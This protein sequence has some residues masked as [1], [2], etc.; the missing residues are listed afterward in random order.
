MTNLTDFGHQRRHTHWSW[1][2][3]L[4]RFLRSGFL[5]FLFHFIL[6]LSFIIICSYDHFMS[7]TYSSNYVMDRTKKVTHPISLW[8]WFLP[9]VAGMHTHIHS[10]APRRWRCRQRCVAEVVSRA[11]GEFCEFSGSELFLPPL[12]QVIVS[13]TLNSTWYLKSRYR[14]IAWFFK[15]NDESPQSGGW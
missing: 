3:S 5:I 1:G 10:V 9:K 6:W 4:T 13:K 2:T 14:K 7:Q 8:Y 15:K 11:S 12:S